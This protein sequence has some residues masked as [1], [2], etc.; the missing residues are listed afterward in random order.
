MLLNL[1]IF[2]ILNVLTT[3]LSPIMNNLKYFEGIR[4]SFYKLFYLVFF[5]C[6]YKL[7]KC[8]FKTTYYVD[9][10]RVQGYLKIKDKYL[11]LYLNQQEITKFELSQEK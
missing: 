1:Y 11:F 4:Q 2:G 5:L 9:L 10:C 6:E 3:F 8:Q 7:Q